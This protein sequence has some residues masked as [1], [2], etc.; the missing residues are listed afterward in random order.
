MGRSKTLAIYS[1][2]QLP[3]PCLENRKKTDP[4]NLSILIS[5]LR[6]QQIA[7]IQNATKKLPGTGIP[8]TIYY[9]VPVLKY[10]VRR[11][12]KTSKVVVVAF[13]LLGEPFLKPLQK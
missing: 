5:T 13:L 7:I 1:K 6:Y 11:Y 2:N 10:L 9:Q 3:P 8:G 12:E 4:Q